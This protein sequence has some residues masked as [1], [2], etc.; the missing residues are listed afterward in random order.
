MTLIFLHHSI[1]WGPLWIA[2]DHSVN[3]HFELAYIFWF[4]FCRLLWIS[5]WNWMRENT[6]WWKIPTSLLS[7]IFSSAC[8]GVFWLSIRDWNQRCCLRSSLIIVLCFLKIVLCSCGCFWEWLCRRT[9]TWGKIIFIMVVCKVSL[10]SLWYFWLHLLLRT[11]SPWFKQKGT[12]F[13]SCTCSNQQCK[14]GPPV[15]TLDIYVIGRARSPA[16]WV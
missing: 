11:V 1:F 9:T 2:N 6:C 4:T 15:L 12:V 8:Y 16:S 10:L 5:V 14:N 3:I 13:C 7:G